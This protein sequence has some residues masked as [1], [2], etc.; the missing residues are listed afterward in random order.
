M[1]IDAPSTI[2]TLP[3]HVYHN[4]ILISNRICCRVCVVGLR[5]ISMTFN[6]LRLQTMPLTDWSRKYASR[7]K[8]LTNEKIAKYGRHIL[9]VCILATTNHCV[10]LLFTCSYFHRH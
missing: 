3:L 2:A 5:Y 6:I 4:I 8:G 9:E 1:L 10:L 7:S